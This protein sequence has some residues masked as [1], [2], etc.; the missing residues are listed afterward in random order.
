MAGAD[1]IFA[2]HLLLAIAG[3]SGSVGLGYLKSMGLD[4]SALSAYMKKNG[5]LAAKS[6]DAEENAAAAHPMSILRIISSPDK[7]AS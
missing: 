2:T 5:L 1:K 6:V 7:I 4:H 3:S